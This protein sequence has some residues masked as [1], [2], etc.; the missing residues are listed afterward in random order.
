MSE[1]KTLN[2]FAIEDIKAR[3]EIASLSETVERIGSIVFCGSNNLYN[4]SMQTEET[5]SP[6]YWTNGTPYY[7]QEGGSTFYDADINA[8]A[9]ISMAEE[10]TYTVGCV[11]PILGTVVLPWDVG[12][13]FATGIMFFD[14]NDVYLGKSQKGTFVTPAGTRYARY[15][16]AKG[17]GVSLKAMN[18]AMM[19]VEGNTLPD[20]YSPHNCI[21]IGKRIKD[22]EN[23]TLPMDV[24]IKSRDTYTVVSPIYKENCVA[25]KFG[26]IGANDLFE[27]HSIGYGKLNGGTYTETAA[28]FKNYA[29]DF[30][31]PVSIGRWD[32]NKGFE[33]GIWSGG[34]HSITVD[35]IAYKTARESSFAAYCDGVDITNS[36]DGIYFGK[37]TFVCINDLYYPQTIT[38]DAFIN[39][40][41]AIEETRTY[42]IC[43]ED[44]KVDVHLRF[45]DTVGVVSYYGM[46][47]PYNISAFSSFYIEG[48]EKTYTKEDIVSPTYFTSPSNMYVINAA[49][50]WTHE[51]ILNAYGLANR[52]KL[53]KKIYGYGNF[54]NGK[55]YQQL[56][57]TWHFEVGQEVA[58]SGNYRISHV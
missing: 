20:T 15:N 44:M 6:H 54:S 48:M 1:I 3:K 57:D 14:E 23:R 8:T 38:D 32:E 18:A 47:Y 22:L 30:I 21:D 50:G 17:A 49:N 52:E 12:G 45:L 35:G 29:S 2:G 34:N 24:V 10:R 25:R 27:I 5:I 19:I 53:S 9:P 26:R 40:T 51:M 43:G 31:G 46:Q 13:S 7:T 56:I 41:K 37:V 39:A 28:V 11:P 4:P 33:N 36:A 42:T 58:W 55:L 16:Y